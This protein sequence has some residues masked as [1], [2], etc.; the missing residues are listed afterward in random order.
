MSV[1]FPSNFSSPSSSYRYTSCETA[2]TSSSISRCSSASF[3]AIVGSHVGAVS[4]GVVDKDGAV[5]ERCT[6]MSMECSRP[7]PQF[8]ALAAPAPTKY[9]RL[10]CMAEVLVEF[11]VVCWCCQYFNIH[12]GRQNFSTCKKKYKYKPHP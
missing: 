8:T 7:A 3:S 1:I 9:E 5:R 4:V 10:S 12:Q 2:L 6:V 11:D